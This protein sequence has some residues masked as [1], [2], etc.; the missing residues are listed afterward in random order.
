[1]IC[2]QCKD[3]K[4]VNYFTQFESGRHRTT[5]KKCERGP[6]TKRR[7]PVRERFNLDGFEMLVHK[8]SI[9]KW[10]RGI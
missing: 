8:L 6:M 2:K 5:C 4:H 3:D 7:G 1:M 10:E 9:S